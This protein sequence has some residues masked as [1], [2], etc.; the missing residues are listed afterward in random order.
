MVYIA[1]DHAGFKLK[2]ELVE[3]FKKLEIEYKDLGPFSFDPL[4]DYPD[5]AYELSKTVVKESSKGIL[6]CKSGIG[7]SICANKVRGI[8]AALCETNLEAIKSREHNNSNVL[9]LNDN[10]NDSLIVYN[11]LVKP[12]LET[13]FAS[14]EER[15]VRRIEKIKAIEEMGMK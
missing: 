7:M 11:D 6:I 8:Y 15:H 14:N 10:D 3:V 5:F 12:W 9:V 4:D 2:Q 1:S 13:E